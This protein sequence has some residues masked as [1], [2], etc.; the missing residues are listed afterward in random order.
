MQQDKRAFVRS[1][2]DRGKF[3]TNLYTGYCRMPVEAAVSGQFLL[4]EKGSI[5]VSVEADANKVRGGKRKH[6]L[7]RGNLFTGG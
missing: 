6:G 3:H 1:T 2:K 4:A 7:T 5:R